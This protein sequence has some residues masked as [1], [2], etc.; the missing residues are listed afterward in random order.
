MIVF[1]LMM[2][3]IHFLC[4]AYNTVVAQVR[5]YVYAVAHVTPSARQR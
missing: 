4:A 5:V 2:I 1:E 3:L